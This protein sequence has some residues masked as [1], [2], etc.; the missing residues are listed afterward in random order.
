MSES[1]GKPPP[2][3]FDVRHMVVRLVHPLEREIM[4]FAL[5]SALDLLLTF[6]LLTGESGSGRTGFNESN[7]LARYFLYSWGFRGLAWFKFA[8]V[9]FVVGICQII[10]LKRV[11]LGRRVLKFASLIVGGV[12][13][14]SVVLML[15]HA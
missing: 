13:V 15:R 1:L 12:V 3:E 10:A 8:L 6:L 5:V 2:M 11:D 7:P 9:A 4:L 14:Y